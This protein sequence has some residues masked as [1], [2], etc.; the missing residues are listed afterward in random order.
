MW[1]KNTFARCHASNYSESTKVDTAKRMAPGDCPRR[2]SMN[3][4]R[5]QSLFSVEGCFVVFCGTVRAGVSERLRAIAA[6]A[7]EIWRN[8]WPGLIRRVK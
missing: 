4:G 2:V 7:D 5:R 8:G 1:V 6:E 3:T